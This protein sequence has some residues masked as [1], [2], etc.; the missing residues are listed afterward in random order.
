MNEFAPSDMAARVAR[1]LGE[2][3][4]DAIRDLLAA[5]VRWGQHDDI[6]GGCQNRREVLTWYRQRRAA[7][8]RAR[9]TEVVPHGEDLLVG[10]VVTGTRAAI[11]EGGEAHRW[12][13][14]SIK[15]GLII[16]IRGFDD[17]AQAAARIGPADC[18]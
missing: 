12:Q 18:C 1:A 9:V 14:L 6:E 17:R 10:L 7:G 4:L 16:D 15:D 2:A 8:T 3:D 5:D 13:V 11:D